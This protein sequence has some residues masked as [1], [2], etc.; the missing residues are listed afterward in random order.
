MGTVAPGGQAQPTSLGLWTPA[1]LSNCCAHSAAHTPQPLAHRGH[2]RTRRFWQLWCLE[3]WQAVASHSTSRCQPSSHARN[4]AGTP[5]HMARAATPLPAAVPC[6]THC[7]VS[8]PGTAAT[9]SRRQMAGH[10]PAALPRQGAA[11]PPRAQQGGVGV[12]GG[13]TQ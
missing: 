2:A 6:S 3:H 11:P 10:K 7:H 8:D 5:M 12:P 9:P 1:A 4:Q 13:A